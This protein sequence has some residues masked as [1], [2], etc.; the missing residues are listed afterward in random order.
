MQRA[1]QRRLKVHAVAAH[2]VAAGAGCADGQA[3]QLLVGDAACDFEQV[4]PEFLF[5]V[6]VHQH[7]LRGI[8]HAAQIAGVARVTSAPLTRGGFEQAHARA[9]FGGHQ[10]RTQGGVAAAN[11]QHIGAHHLSLFCQGAKCC[12]NSAY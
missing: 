1:R 4:L 9:R 3:G 10:G 7:V 6:G 2:P 12:R 5:G 11:H 8:M